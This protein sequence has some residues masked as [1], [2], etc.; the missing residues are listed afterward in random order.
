[1]IPLN[2]MIRNLLGLLLVSLL[3]AQS[4]NADA[5][6]DIMPLPQHVT[7]NGFRLPVGKSLTVHYSKLSSARLQ[8][9]TERLAN[10][11]QTR[12]SVETKVVESDESKA[13]LV[14]S[15][16]SLSPEIPAVSADESY[17]LDI[18]SKHAVLHATNEIGVLR[19]HI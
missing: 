10:A 15:C 18:N 1:M 17:S 16:D 13:A 4:A 6:I 8:H 11:W 3:C 12:T 2:N 14:I 7:L 5:P 19:R 9:A